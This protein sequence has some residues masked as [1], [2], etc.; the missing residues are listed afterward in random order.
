[1]KIMGICTSSLANSCCRSRP[2]RPGSW[3][4]STRQLGAPGR[5]LV[6]NSCAEAKVWTLSPTE[7]MRLLRLSRMDR[8]SSTTKTHGVSSCMA[9][10]PGA[11]RPLYQ[12]QHVK[13]LGSRVLESRIDRMEEV[14]L[15]AGF[16]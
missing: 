11:F 8:S 1:M 4:S 7:R 3:T 13:L 14:R 15:A 12:C 10:P 2:L 9:Y 6:K 16:G 5:W